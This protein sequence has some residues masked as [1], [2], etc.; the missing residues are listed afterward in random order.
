MKVINVSAYTL[1]RISLV[2]LITGAAFA[3]R[4]RAVDRLPVD[5]DE[6]DYFTAA[7]HYAG[8]IL[9]RDWREIVDYAYI[10]EHPTLYKL[11]YG[12]TLAFLPQ[13][14]EVPV[15]PVTAEPTGDLPQPHFKILRT[16]S[17]S[18]GT[19]QVLVLALLNPL[20]GFLLAIN[21]F[22]IKYTS[23]IYLEALPGLTSL[24]AVVAYSRWRARVRFGY[25]F[26]LFLSAVFLGLSAA[27]KYPYALVGLAVLVHWMWVTPLRDRVNRSG[28]VKDWRLPVL[29]VL[30]SI[31]IFLLADPYLWPDPLNRLVDS[32]LYWP[33]FAS[34]SHVQSAGYPFWQP[35]VWLL[36]SVPWHPGVFIFAIDGL[37]AVLA[38]AGIPRLWRKNSVFAVWLVFDLGLLFL[39]PTKWAQYILVLTAP[40]ALAAAEG[41]Q[42]LIWEPTI[43]WL[44]RPKKFSWSKIQPDLVRISWGEARQAIPWLLPGLIAL[45]LIAIFPLVFQFAMSL[46]D[47]QAV[48]IKDGLTGGIWREVWLG[49]TRQVE[50]VLVDPFSRSFSR[51]KQVHYAGTSLLLRLFSGIGVDILIFEALWTLLSV[52][53]QLGLGVAV[54]MLLQ[55]KGVLF[56]RGWQAI[57]ILPW[58]IPEFLGALVWARMFEPRFGWLFVGQ[59][60][61]ETPGYPFVSQL[62]AW[63]ENPDMALIVLLIAGTWYGFP[64]MMIAASAALKMIPT[65]VYEAAALDG[66]GTWGRLRW[67]TWP[68]ILPL[69]APAMIIRAIFAFNQFYLFYVLQTPYPAITFAT[70]SFFLFDANSGF[71]GQFAVSAAI[72]IFTLVILVIFLLFFNR[73]SKATEG[74]TYA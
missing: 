20:A 7:Q 25:D 34:G 70:L 51:I 72:N 23:Q 71:G 18:L 66:A 4:M 30:T 74:V 62:S 33:Q 56:K 19:L 38:L 27:S 57:F 8:A 10:Q 53:C 42:G 49:L 12:T 14:P 73:W 67:V 64:L 63:Q 44:R 60:F 40:L 59:T 65:E 31:C 29:W 9:H 45:G 54:A 52:V 32:L 68:M 16:I 36:Q 22:T 46:T 15:R 11:V 37:V 55:R 26:R 24:L 43:G 6:D 5:Y 2:L 48:A 61:S 28:L 39:W 50:P 58:A 21:T 69:L 3:L 13:L 1:L 41:F 47:F 35:M 17:A